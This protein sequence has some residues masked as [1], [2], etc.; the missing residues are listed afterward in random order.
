MHARAACRLE[1]L[2]FTPVYRYSPGKADWRAMGWSTQG[3]H[4]HTI[5][6]IHAVTRD[7]PTCSLDEPVSVAAER[8][9]HAGVSTCIVFDPTGI[10]LGRLH[11]RALTADDHRPAEAVMENGPTTTRPDED[12]AAVVE[13]MTRR[14][15]TELLVTDPDGRLIGILYRTEAESVLS[16]KA[17]S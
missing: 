11:G 14:H 5:R 2:G 17:R 6:A 12:L 13:R 9:N 1:T 8:A 16:D 3:R 7:V 10:V 15:V 4:A